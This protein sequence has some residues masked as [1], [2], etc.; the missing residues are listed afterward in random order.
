MNVAVVA[1]LE[2]HAHAVTGRVAAGATTTLVDILRAVA[3]NVMK[4]LI[5][6]A[7]VFFVLAALTWP[8]SFLA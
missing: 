4:G 7:L 8:P 3:P 1:G 6:P 5:L 2:H